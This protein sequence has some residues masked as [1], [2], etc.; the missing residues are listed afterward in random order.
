MQPWTISWKVASYEA[1]G[2]VLPST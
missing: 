2:H 1:L